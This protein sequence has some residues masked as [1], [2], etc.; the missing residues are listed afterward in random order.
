MFDGVKTPSL[1]NQ[2]QVPLTKTEHVKRITANENLLHLTALDRRSNNE[3]RIKPID[4][5]NQTLQASPSAKQPVSQKQ[6]MQATAATGWYGRKKGGLGT[7]LKPTD[8]EDLH[9]TSR[10]KG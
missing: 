3:V 8:F 7:N 5:M 6:K 10:D 4:P 1:K 9:I 2:S